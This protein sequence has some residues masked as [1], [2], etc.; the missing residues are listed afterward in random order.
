MNF[1][2]CRP[3]LVPERTSGSSFH[4]ER[5]CK[6]KCGNCHGKF[7]LLDTPY[8]LAQIKNIEKQRACL[9]SMCTILKYS[10]TIEF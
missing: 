6:L 1:H 4:P 5:T 7:G 2:F 3:V 10:I 9:E 8:H